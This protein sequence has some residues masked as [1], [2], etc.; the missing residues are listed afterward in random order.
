MSY[1][2]STNTNLQT[3]WNDL[4]SYKYRFQ[5]VLESE[6]ESMIYDSMIIIYYYPFGI[7]YANAF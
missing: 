6:S 1:I 7:V 5:N 2:T 4:D 3:V